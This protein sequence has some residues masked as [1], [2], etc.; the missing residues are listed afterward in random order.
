MKKIYFV[1]SQKR[2]GT[3]YL[4]GVQIEHALRRTG[5]DCK[6]VLLKH[7]DRCRDGIVV[8]VKLFSVEAAK[9]AIAGNNRIVWDILDGYKVDLINQVSSS[10]VLDGLITSTCASETALACLKPR[11]MALI[12]HHIDPRLIRKIK[13]KPKTEDFSICYIGNVPPEI[14]GKSFTEAFAD[15]KQIEVNTRHAERCGWMRNTAPFQCHFAVR[16]DPWECQMKPLAKVGV[17]AACNANIIVNR[18]NAAVE[19]L[20]ADYPFL[21]DDSIED[22]LRTIE[23]ARSEFGSAIWR[24]GLERMAEL[25]DRL[26]IEKNVEDYSRFFSRFT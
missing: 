7:L 4:R 24:A 14:S 11:E 22:A 13:R 19:L 16:L 20:G 3:Y 23:R 15:V 17:A 9:R 26:S 1:V 18:S 5:V 6:L 25:R 2:W 21:C 8:F 10:I 12:Y